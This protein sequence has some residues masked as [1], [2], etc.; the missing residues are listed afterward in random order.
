[1]V[2]FLLLL[3]F[4]ILSIAGLLVITTQVGAIIMIVCGF[5]GAVGM[6]FGSYRRSNRLSRR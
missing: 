1:M 6:G 5:V 3:I 2:L 4:G